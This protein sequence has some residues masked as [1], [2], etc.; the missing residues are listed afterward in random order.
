[1]FKTFVTAA[2]LTIAATS[3]VA[4]TDAQT[5]TS[6][7]VDVGDLDLSQPG[8]RQRADRRITATIRSMCETSGPRTLAIR[9][10]EA[11]CREQAQ[12]SVRPRGF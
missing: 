2:G 10:A 5:T 7:A 8:D 6:I 11:V 4:A 9:T 1:M 3:A 12:A